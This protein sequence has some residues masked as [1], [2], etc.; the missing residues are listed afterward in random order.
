MAA[1]TDTY[2]TIKGDAQAQFVEQRSRFIS[3]IWHV[4]SADEVKDRIAALPKE[5]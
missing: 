2:Q 5:Y 1:A 4:S 3:F